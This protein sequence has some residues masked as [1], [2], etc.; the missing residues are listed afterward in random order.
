MGEVALGAAAE[1]NRGRQ[2]MW[3]DAVFGR[4]RRMS[5]SK[6]QVLLFAFRRRHVMRGDLWFYPVTVAQFIEEL[7]NRPI[8]EVVWETLLCE[9][10]Y[11]KDYDE[12][13]G[14][15]YWFC[16]PENEFYGPVGRGTRDLSLESYVAL[17]DNVFIRVTEKDNR[18][19]QI[20]VFFEGILVRVADVVDNLNLENLAFEVYVENA[21]SVEIIM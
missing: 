2:R 6:I 15:Q 17:Y 8:H 16:Q 9:E 3:M 1:S 11:A 20:E 10:F 14:W 5:K 13:D 21:A 12:L 19:W 18:M 7:K 4:I